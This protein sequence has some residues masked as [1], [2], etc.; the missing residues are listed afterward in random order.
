MKNKKTSKILYGVIVLLL[1]FTIMTFVNNNKSENSNVVVP[2]NAEAK[3][4]NVLLDKY[5]TD[6][7]PVDCRLGDYDDDVKA[8]KEHLSHHGNTQ[9]CLEYYSD[10]N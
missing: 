9:Y 6:P 3:A 5:R 4:A 8:W 2:N 7:V 1:I 10:I